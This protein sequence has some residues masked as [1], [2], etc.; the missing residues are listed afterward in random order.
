MNESA[1]I[2]R[3]ID[4][5]RA[6]ELMGETYASTQKGAEMIKEIADA[7]ATHRSDLNSYGGL[8]V[9]VSAAIY[10]GILNQE[11]PSQSSLRL[12]ARRTKRMAIVGQSRRDVNSTSEGLLGRLR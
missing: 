4:A 3:C 7:L 12:R 1:H 6:V 5:L 11:P 2:A 9:Q 10:R 8:C